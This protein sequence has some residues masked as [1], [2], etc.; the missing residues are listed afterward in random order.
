[1]I[2][3]IPFWAST[4]E[5]DGSSYRDTRYEGLVRLDDHGL[6]LEFREQVTEIGGGTVQERQE[7][8]REVRIPTEAIR[9]VEYRHRYLRRPILDIELARL[10]PAE[11]VPWARG[12]RVR[13]RVSRK[14][15]SHAHELGSELRLLQADARLRELGEGDLASG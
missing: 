2:A 13:V 1:M 4:G 14:D 7:G 8:V 6:V 10:G 3:T 11:A 12:T 9:S 15:R 5:M